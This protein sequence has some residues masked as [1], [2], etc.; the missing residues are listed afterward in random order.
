MNS[1]L[2]ILLNLKYLEIL[3]I[4]QEGK[5]FLLSK[6]ASSLLKSI[7][8]YYQEINSKDAQK[9]FRIFFP[10]LDT[11]VISSREIENEEELYRFVRE[12]LENI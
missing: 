9:V 3:S 8:N 10:Y 2:N 6:Y 7:A 11:R 12:L 4:E 5:R 1:N